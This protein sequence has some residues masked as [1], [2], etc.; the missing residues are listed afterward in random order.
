MKMHAVCVVLFVVCGQTVR[1]AGARETRLIVAP[2]ETCGR[3]DSA[4][5]TV[6]VVAGSTLHIHFSSLPVWTFSEVAPA[7]VSVQACNAVTCRLF[8]LH[9]LVV[10]CAFVDGL[11]VSVYYSGRAGRHVLDRPPTEQNMRTIVGLLIM[12]GVVG[13]FVYS[14][15]PTPIAGGVKRDAQNTPFSR[16]STVI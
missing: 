2:P 14:W 6:N 12:L 7:V 8:T 3:Q 11:G 15:R 10:G 13:Y 16:S 4:A 1:A 5:L 9:P